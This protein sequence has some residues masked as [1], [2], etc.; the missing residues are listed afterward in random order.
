MLVGKNEKGETVQ[1]PQEIV[2]LI[3]RQGIKT[4]AK[5]RSLVKN[6]CG[7]TISPPSVEEQLSGSGE[8][9]EY[10]KAGEEVK[11]TYAKFN[12][13]I[14]PDGTTVQAPFVRAE[15]VPALYQ[16]LKRLIQNK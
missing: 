11:H 1:V 4:F 7:I 5:R 10:A 15:L 12:N 14:L 2:D 16:E 8:W 6:T 3:E 9:V 13:V